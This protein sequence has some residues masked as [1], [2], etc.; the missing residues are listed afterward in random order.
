MDNKITHSSQS[1]ANGLSPEQLARVKIDSMLQDAGWEIVSRDDYTPGVS[2]AAIEEGL[3]QGQLEADYLLFLEGKAIG[4]L[5]AKKSSSDLSEIVAAQAENYTHQLLPMYQYWEDP[6]PFIYL[7]NGKELL[8]RNLKEP[9]GT[10]HPLK[11]MHTP[12]A[13]AKL[14]GITSYFIGLPRLEKDGLYD[15][16]IDAITSLEASFRTGQQRALIS[17]ATGAGKT[18]IACMS[19]YRFLTYTPARRVLFLVDRNNLG[20]QAHAAFGIFDKT[21]TGAHFTDIYSTSRWAAAEFKIGSD[22][23]VKIPDT[24][25]VV[26]TIQRLYSVISGCELLEPDEQEDAE[27]PF[28][29]EDGPAVE[30]TGQL[31]LPPDYFDFIFVDECHRSIYGRWKKVLTYFDHARIIGL[32]ATPGEETMAFFNNNRIVNYTLEE[33]VADGINV[34]YRI[35][36]I[37]TEATMNGGIVSE[38]DKYQEVTVYTG[39]R[40]NT[41]AVVPWSYQ[42]SDLDRAVVNPEQIRLVLE[43]F[44]DAVYEDLYPNRT[45]DFACLPKTLIFA[46]SDSHADN[47]LSILR[48]VFPGQAPEFAQKITYSAGDSNTL[49]KN[50]RNDRKFRIAVTVTLVATGTDVKPLEILLFMRDVNSESLFIQMRGRG[51]RRIPDDVLRNVTPN[52]D[53]KDHF[54]IVDAVG[55]TRHP[56]QNRPVT[57]D[58][59]GRVI[60]SLKQ[61]LEQIAHGW[62]PDENLRLL[63]MRLVRIH[64]KYK[65]PEHKKFAALSGMDMVEIAKHIQDAFDSGE[66][67]AAPFEHPNEPNLLRKALVEPLAIHPEARKY[68]LELHYGYVEILQPGKDKL[69]AKGF[70]KE[71]ALETTTE[72]ESYLQQHKNEEEAIRIVADEL[73]SPITYDMLADLAGKLKA[74][75][76]EFQPATLWYAYS[77]LDPEKVVPLKAEDKDAQTNLIQ[78]MRFAFGG[79]PGKLQSL[80]SL[81]AQRFELW[82]GEPQRKVLTDVQRRLTL[83]LT[84]YIVCNGACTQLNISNGIGPQFLMQVRSAFGAKNV[85]TLL[86][87][88]SAFMLAA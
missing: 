19:A 79:H 57:G 7:S 16:Q 36:N 59:G 37:D 8:F 21:E 80:R 62:L 3:L 43:T 63:A 33:S 24:N 12:K 52:A 60:V 31:Q 64:D 11:K 18:Y 85:D 9:D 29:P 35:Y 4:V 2:A 17:V 55:V 23:R 1:S 56:M 5:E 32:T 47:I 14:A 67:D 54:T 78:L 40:R 73:D 69:V 45:P 15:C 27:T 34:G 53:T 61:L 88:L 22:G 86:K 76:S 41:R 10:Y 72:F 71:K 77:V 49:I 13:M 50:F 87:S 46:K 39:K 44:R 75:N 58:D 51:C 65:E 68:L 6:L 30:L 25:V 74:V 48:E 81:S 83:E 42:S 84:N 66:L 28:D 26:C 20:K 38:G 70:S 82:C